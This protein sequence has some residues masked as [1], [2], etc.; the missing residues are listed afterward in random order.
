M[1]PSFRE[2][3]LS[4]KNAGFLYSLQ[5]VNAG[6]EFNDEHFYPRAQLSISARMI[7]KLGS[8]DVAH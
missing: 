3:E 5:S 7:S 4:Q 6:M 1:M 8:F 2:A